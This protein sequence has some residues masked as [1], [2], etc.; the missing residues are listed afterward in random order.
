MTDLADRIARL[1]A[2]AEIRDL[3]TRYARACDPYPDGALI[4][5]MFSEDGVFD[6]GELFGVHR[7]RDA[8]REH[9]LRG[10]E[11]LKW[12]LHLIES[13]LIEVGED[14]R[15]A[16]GTWYLWQ[17]MTTWEGEGSA[18]ARWL[19]GEYHD[20][21]R[22]DELGTWRFASVKLEIG[23]YATYEEGWEPVAGE[24]VGDGGVSR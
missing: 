20:T 12:A 16:T 2:L 15:S 4:A 11:V 13:P 21:Y 7:G 23:I 18:T 24:A 6:C 5:T 22:R 17:P 1:E 8:I 14:L 19:A 9:F 3:K 10:P